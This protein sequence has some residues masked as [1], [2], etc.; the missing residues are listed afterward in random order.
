MVFR[1]TTYA[2]NGLTRGLLTV[3][4]IATLFCDL[5]DSME[6]DQK[7]FHYFYDEN[8][9]GSADFVAVDTNLE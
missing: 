3:T 1:L 7:L 2:S 6:R 5:V 9:L 4:T 8:L